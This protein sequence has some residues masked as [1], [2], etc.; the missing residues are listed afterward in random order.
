MVEVLLTDVR[1]SEARAETGDAD[2]TRMS[3]VLDSVGIGDGVVAGT[4]AGRCR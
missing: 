1:G 4:D 3:L 2:T